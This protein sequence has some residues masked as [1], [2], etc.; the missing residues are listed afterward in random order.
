MSQSGSCLGEIRK[1]NAKSKYQFRVKFLIQIFVVNKGVMFQ[2]VEITST[3]EEDE[4]VVDDGNR[5][6]MTLM[7]DDMQ[8][9]LCSCVYVMKENHS[10]RYSYKKSGG[11]N[12]DKMDIFRIERLWKDDK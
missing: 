10:R 9:R 1:K 7:R 4:D 11:L 8:I 12:K 3:P 6:Y 2:E 5:Y